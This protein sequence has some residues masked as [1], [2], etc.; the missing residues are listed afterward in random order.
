M[1]MLFFK[2]V[3]R[4][5]FLYAY[6]AKNKVN[7]SSADTAT[8]TT[9]TSTRTIQTSLKSPPKSP[10]NSTTAR[11]DNNKND[12][13]KKAQTIHHKSHNIDFSRSLR[14]AKGLFASFMLFTLCW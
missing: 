14:I 1:F 13:S 3:L 6:G 2:I 7:A 9:V 12:N 8:L 10:P 4:R 5:I 11:R